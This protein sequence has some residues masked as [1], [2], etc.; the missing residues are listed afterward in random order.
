MAQNAF[1]SPATKEQKQAE[2]EI[3]PPEVAN[4]LATVDKYLREGDPKQALALLSRTKLASPYIQ[5]AVGVCQLR[6][7]QTQA[8]VSKFRGMAV[9]DTLLVRHDTPT[10][11]KT[12]HATALLVSKNLSG[13]LRMLSDLK[14]ENHPTSQ[15]L[16]AAIQRWK[17]NLS[18]WQKIQWYTGSELDHPVELDFPPGDLE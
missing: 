8:A 18:L 12:N 1:S 9:T 10:V 13:C 16:H 5:N 17:S 6:L 15:K 3:K 4:L 7:G 2:H 11:C 14:N